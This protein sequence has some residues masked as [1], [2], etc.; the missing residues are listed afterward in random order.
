MLAARAEIDS[1]VLEGGK[2]TDT[3]ALDAMTAGALAPLVSH[4]VTTG[5]VTCHP[6][7]NSR[8][9]DHLADAFKPKI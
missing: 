1:L 5:A 7:T 2:I 3:A 9:P 4:T 6:Y 8:G